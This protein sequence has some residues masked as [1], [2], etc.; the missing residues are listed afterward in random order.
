VLESALRVA[1]GDMAPRGTSEAAPRDT[2]HQAIDPVAGQL[3]D[4]LESLDQEGA[5]L[6]ML[7]THGGVVT[8]RGEDEAVVRYEIGDDVR[9][10]T[11]QR[12]QFADERLPDEGDRV[13]IFVQVTTCPKKPTESAD[14]PGAEERHGGG[15]KRQRDLTAQPDF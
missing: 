8:E 5:R 2:S 15:S 12:D 4:L 3:V 1:L 14:E 9:D 7:E 11:Y 6:A 10:H 13:R